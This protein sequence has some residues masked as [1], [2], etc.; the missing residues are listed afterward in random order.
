[1]LLK[2]RN[3]LEEELLLQVL[4]AGG[5]HDALAGE[6]RGNQ[7]SQRLAGA[8]AGFHDQMFAVGQRRFHRFGHGQLAG[9]IFVIRV[10][11]GKR[12]VPRE[13]LMHAG[14]G[15]DIGGHAG[16]NSIVA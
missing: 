7:V 2:E 10:P 6:D 8:R 4:G 5:N 3:V 14:S 9:T 16:V 12:A 11:L 1:M 15:F 13:E